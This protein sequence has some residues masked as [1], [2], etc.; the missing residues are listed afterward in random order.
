[1]TPINN[2]DFGFYLNYDD[3]SFMPSDNS[4]F[5]KL[6]FDFKFSINP[7]VFL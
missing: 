3:S 6:I 2:D 4:G 5:L 1:M 7:I